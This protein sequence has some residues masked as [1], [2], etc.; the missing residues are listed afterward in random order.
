MSILHLLLFYIIT[1]NVT[2][3]VSKMAKIWASNFYRQS[4]VWWMMFFFVGRSSD[5]V[6]TKRSIVKADNNDDDVDVPS[7]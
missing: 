3:R 6:A 5:N 1:P 2:K 4:D 7:C